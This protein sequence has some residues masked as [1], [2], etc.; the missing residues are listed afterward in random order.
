MIIEFIWKWLRCQSLCYYHSKVHS[1]FRCRDRFIISMR[2]TSD[3][4]TSAPAVP[5]LVPRIG[6]RIQ[7]SIG[8]LDGLVARNFFGRDVLDVGAVV[9]LEGLFGSMY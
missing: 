7:R 3:V 8:E 4:S 2:N 9:A 5:P 6:Q 1:S